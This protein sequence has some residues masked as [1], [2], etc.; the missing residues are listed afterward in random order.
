MQRVENWHMMD[1]RLET[2]STQEPTKWR[3]FVLVK[4]RTLV[5]THAH[6]SETV[7]N[8]GRA[9]TVKKKC[10][11]CQ[12]FKSCRAD[13]RQQQLPRFPKRLFETMSLDLMGPYP[14]ATNGKKFMLVFT[15]NYSCWVDACPFSGM[16]AKHCEGV[17]AKNLVRWRYSKQLLTYNGTQFTGRR[18]QEKCT[19]EGG[20]T[21]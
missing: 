1:G 4:K 5:L 9:Q 11:T 16:C 19:Q 7:G 18:F 8:P 15:D 10:V 12:R 20:Y 21:I 3:L 14:L 17:G 6:A 2:C 13:G